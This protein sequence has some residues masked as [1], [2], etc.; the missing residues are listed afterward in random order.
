MRWAGFG[1]LLLLMPPVYGLPHSRVRTLAVTEGNHFW[2]LANSRGGV[3]ICS[4]GSKSKL[5]TDLLPMQDP[6]LACTRLG[7][8]AENRL[9]GGLEG[10]ASGSLG[11]W[12]WTK[13]RVGLPRLKP[14]HCCCQPHGRTRA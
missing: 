11:A 10:A 8:F 3:G 6:L 9:A 2:F 4:P 5:L 14:G 13:L 1:V 12:G 7:L